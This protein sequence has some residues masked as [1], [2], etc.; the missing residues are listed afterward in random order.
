MYIPA[1]ASGKENPPA[2]AGDTRDAGWIPGSERSPG[3]G[4][5]NP[6]QYSCLENLID[7]GGWQAMVHSVA[8]L[9]TTEGTQQTHIFITWPFWNS[10]E[11]PVSKQNHIKHI[12][13]K[14]LKTEKED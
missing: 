12:I 7:R 9:D 2:S 13:V 3:G 4:H 10:V 11:C 5:N 1:G 8:K 6:L 14:L